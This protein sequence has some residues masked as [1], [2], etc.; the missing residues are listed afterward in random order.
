MMVWGRSVND[1]MKNIFND[2]SAKELPKVCRKAETVR[3]WYCG[4]PYIIRWEPS[5]EIKQFRLYEHLDGAI[6]WCKENCNG[7]YTTNVFR[8]TEFEDSSNWGFDEF[9]G[10]DLCF[11]AFTDERDLLMFT[12]KW[13]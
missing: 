6:K 10:Y 13:A 11:F 7:E 5:D 1:L 12:L 2:S 8:V 9:S 4:Y 3:G